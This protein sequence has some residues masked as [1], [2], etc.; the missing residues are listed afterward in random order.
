MVEE[1]VCVYIYT[2]THTQ[3]HRHT[4]THTVEYYSAIKK[5]YIHK[6]E[7]YS[8]IKNEILYLPFVTTW[9]NLEVIMLREI[10]QIEKE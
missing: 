1:V 8:G 3:T 4:H 2:D 9:M 5:K 6:I 7:Y 10:S